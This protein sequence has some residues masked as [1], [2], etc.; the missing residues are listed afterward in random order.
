MIDWK[1]IVRVRMKINYRRYWMRSRISLDS[2]G[3]KWIWGDQAR[4][5]DAEKIGMERDERINR[6]G[7]GSLKWC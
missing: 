1:G 3:S 2:E 4:D 5:P 7:C 6:R